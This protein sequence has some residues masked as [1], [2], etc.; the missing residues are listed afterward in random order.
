MKAKKKKKDGTDTVK[1]L[2]G[3]SRGGAWKAH[4]AEVIRLGSHT[5]GQSERKC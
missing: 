1:H 2:V 5:R 3:H 4:G